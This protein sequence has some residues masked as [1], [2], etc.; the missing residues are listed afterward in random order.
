MSAAFVSDDPKMYAARIWRN[1]V[2]NDSETHAAETTAAA[3]IRAARDAAMNTER[4]AADGFPLVNS[5]PESA[6]L[7]EASPGHQN[8]DIVNCCAS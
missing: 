5:C 2:Q 7:E 6:F 3:E 1:P 4:I 8:L